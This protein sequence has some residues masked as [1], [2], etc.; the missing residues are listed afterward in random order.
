MRARKV[1]NFYP[2]EEPAHAELLE[3]LE[4]IEGERRRQQALLQM[5]LIGFRVMVKHESGE[6][7]HFRARNPD[8]NKLLGEGARGLITGVTRVERKPRK[9]PAEMIEGKAEQVDPSPAKPVPSA[10]V[11]RITPAPTVSA[12]VYNAAPVVQEKPIEHKVQQDDE[13]LLDPLALLRHMSEGD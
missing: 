6:E 1:L 9:R 10:A 2:D 8:L 12:P 5:A 7:A 13:G 3:Y 4:G 11:E